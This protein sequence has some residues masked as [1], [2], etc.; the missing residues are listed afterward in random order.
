MR[1]RRRLEIR[2]YRSRALCRLSALRHCTK[3]IGSGISSKRTQS[4][5]YG[6][7]CLLGLVSRLARRHGPAMSRG[8]DPTTTDHFASFAVNGMAA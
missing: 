7:R 2:L 5:P 1:L 4:G 6:G 8:Y 3:G